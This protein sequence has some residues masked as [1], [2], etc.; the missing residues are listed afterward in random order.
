MHVYAQVC[1]NTLQ[2]A[3]ISSFARTLLAD[4]SKNQSI[5]NTHIHKDIK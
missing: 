2:S 5:V 3:E 1:K 4:L